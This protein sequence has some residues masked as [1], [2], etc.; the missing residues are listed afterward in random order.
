MVD[1]GKLPYKRLARKE[2]IVAIGL[3]PCSSRVTQSLVRPY[4]PDSGT[5]RDLGA[6]SIISR[7]PSFRM[8]A[9]SPKKFELPKSSHS[10]LLSLLLLPFFIITI[11]LCVSR[12]QYVGTA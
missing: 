7:S 4:Q 5:S 11:L 10:L 9:S 8:M 6:E 2:Q 1:L 3:P 12:Y